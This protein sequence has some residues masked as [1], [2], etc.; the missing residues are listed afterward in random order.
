[1]SEAA[2]KTTAPAANTGLG[3]RRATNAAGN[4]ASASARL[5]E[6]S[7]QASVW[8]STSYC[9]RI[10]GSAIVTTDES[11]RTIPTESPRSAMRVRAGTEW[12]LDRPDTMEGPRASELQARPLDP[13][14]LASG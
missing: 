14:F 1:M 8:I 11:A 13:V 5:N 7:A 12:S 3:R 4:A 2:A 9:A 10:S 6:V